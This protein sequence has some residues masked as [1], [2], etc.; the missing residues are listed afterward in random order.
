MSCPKSCQGLVVVVAVVVVVPRISQKCGPWALL[1][2]FSGYARARQK[3]L[4]S[5]YYANPLGYLFLSLSAR[6][7]F[8]VER[9]VVKGEGHMALGRT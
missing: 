4:V 5:T 8:L 1:L 2:D 7:H 9:G 6:Q 3:K